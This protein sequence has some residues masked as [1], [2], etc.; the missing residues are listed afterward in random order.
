MNVPLVLDEEGVA[1]AQIEF[2]VFVRG[3]FQSGDGVALAVRAVGEFVAVAADP[4]V[5][6]RA[7][8]LDCEIGAVTEPAQHHVVFGRFVGGAA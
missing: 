1:A 6:F 7:L 8:F 2:P 4:D 3:V 5:T